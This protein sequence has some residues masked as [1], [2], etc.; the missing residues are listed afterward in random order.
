MR[1]LALAAACLLLVLS[2]AAAQKRQMKVLAIGNSFTQDACEQNL[3]ELGAVDGTAYVI[4]NLYIGACTLERHCR[5]AETD[6]AAYSY[7]KIG[8]DGTKR[9][10]KGVRLSEAL[11]DEAW[12]AVVFQQGHAGYGL[13]STHEPWLGQ[14]L[15]YVRER[16]PAGTRF[17][18]QESWAFEPGSVNPDFAFYGRDQWKMYG[19][20]CATTGYIAGKYGLEAIPTA[21]AM[22]NARASE[23]RAGV[24]RDGHHLNPLGQFTVACTWHEILSGKDVTANRYRPRHIE[25]WQWETALQ[26]AHQA[27]L[28]PG[29]PASVGPQ[30]HRALRDEAGVPSYTLPDPLVMEDGTPVK[31]REQWFD[32]RR[33][34]LLRLFAEK[35]FGRSPEGALEGQHWTTVEAGT[36]VF[37]GL[38]VRRQVDL[39]LDKSDRYCLHLIMYL[40]KKAGKP[41]PVF[42]G[43]N[44]QGNWAL[45]EDD[46]VPA[47]DQKRLKRYGCL[48]GI[49]V[50]WPLA[51]I[52]SAGFGV[53]SFYRGDADPDYD[54]GFRNGI[55]PLIYGKGQTYPGPDQW[56]TIA[57]WAWALSRAMDY[58]E[59]DKS[60]DA[61]KVAVIGHSRLGKTALW[62]GAC[63]PR[64]AMVVS[65]CSGAGGAALSRRVFGETLQDLN[66]HFPHWYCRNFHEYSGR[67]SELPFDQHELLALIAPRPLYVASADEDLWADPKGEFLSAKQASRVYEFL[68]VPGLAAE[69]WPASGQVSQEGTVAYH[70][71]PGRHDSTPWDWEQYLK[72]AGKCFGKR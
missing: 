16:V 55:T 65:N 58:L 50:R 42:L 21:T 14:L 72:F 63:D 56:G 48:D 24:T 5:N 15:A 22:Q 53:V 70:L 69:S 7:R 54:D 43:I 51:Q 34:E 13:V 28:S 66:R 25:K 10:R 52:L 3:W 40:P 64:F 38:G 61:S 35:M 44:F 12:D 18:L 17:L 27:V 1:R 49:D 32:E 9:V 30:A 8:L 47:P 45:G 20:I 36:E 29:K 11:S 26:A 19:D 33:P 41:A 37:G 6:A 67:E 68:G 60:V 59:T 62:A 4:G 39:Y 31:T 46:G 2:S 57:Q 71:R 23:I